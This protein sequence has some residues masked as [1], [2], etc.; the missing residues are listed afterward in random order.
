[1][2]NAFGAVGRDDLMRVMRA[3]GNQLRFVGV[4]DDE[5]AVATAEDDAA[6]V[7]VA[8]DLQAHHL[9]VELA[10][11]GQVA[12]TQAGF[13]DTLGL[14]GRVPRKIELRVDCT[15]TDRIVINRVSALF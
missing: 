10:D 11:G 12:A 13:E 15:S 4:E 3:G 5:D 2:A 14:H 8:D 9:C 7:H 6:R 1:M